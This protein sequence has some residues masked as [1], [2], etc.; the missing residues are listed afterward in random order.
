MATS[1]MGMPAAAGMSDSGTN[2]MATSLIRVI[3]ASSSAEDSGVRSSRA[4]S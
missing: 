3:P 4:T 2:T 1:S